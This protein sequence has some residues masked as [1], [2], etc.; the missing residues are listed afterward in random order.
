ML[1]S[2]SQP[3]A[4]PCRARKRQA[5][6]SATRNHWNHKVRAGA[7]PGREEAIFRQAETPITQALF[8]T[9]SLRWPPPSLGKGSLE[10]T[11]PWRWRLFYTPGGAAS[12]SSSL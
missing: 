12:S 6:G 11:W 5:W 8:F 2:C 3:H 10:N 1:Q 9:D 4:E 7:S